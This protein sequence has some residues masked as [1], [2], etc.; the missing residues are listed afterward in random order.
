MAAVVTAIG[1]FCPDLLRRSKMVRRRDCGTGRRREETKG[2]SMR[3]LLIAVAAGALVAGL[4]GYVQA[5]PAKDPMCAMGS[6]ATNQ[7]WQDHYHC[8]AGPMAKP[9]AA[10]PSKKDP[11]CSMGSQSTNQGWADHYG[12]WGPM[13]HW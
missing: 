2:K 11:M 8:W 4:A 1:A 5:A 9:V 3:K 12:C 6:Q 13:K 7:G 10:K